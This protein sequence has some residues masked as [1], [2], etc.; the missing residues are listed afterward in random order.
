MSKDIKTKF[1]EALKLFDNKE[2]KQCKK[3]CIKG[4]EKTPNN[5]DLLSLKGITMAFL[6]EKEEGLK[7]IKDAIKIKFS[8]PIPWHFLALYYKEEKD[9]TQA[10]K[11]YT[12]ALK[13][14]SGN[15]NILRE[16]SYLQLYLRLYESFFESAKLGLEMRNSLIVNWTTYSFAGYLIG[17]YEFSEKI[18][19]STIRLLGENVKANELHELKLFKIKLLVKQSK[20]NEAIDYLKSNEKE[21]IDKTQYNQDLCKL[22][23]H[24]NDYSSAEGCVDKLIQINNEN[25]EYILIKYKILLIQNQT[26]FQVESLT[27]FNDLVNIY[28]SSSED[29]RKSLLNIYFQ[30]KTNDKLKLDKSKVGY[31]IELV[32][33]NEEEFKIHINKYLKNGIFTSN[34][35]ILIYIEW[36]YV[37]QPKKLSLIKEIIH[38]LIN[39]YSQSQTIYGSDIVPHI[40]WFHYYLSLHFKKLCDFKLALHY[41]NLSIDTTPTVVDFFVLKSK[42]L[43]KIFLFKEADKSYNKAR[44]LDVGDRYLNAKH[45]KILLRSDLLENSQKVMKEF[46]KDP[47]IDENIEHVQ[48]CWYILESSELH[49]RNGEIAQGERLLLSVINIFNS[50]FEDEFD[51]FNYCLR[52]NCVYTFSESLEYMDRLFENKNIFKSLQLINYLYDCLCIIES[53]NE[54][55]KEMKEKECLSLN[56]TVF[57]ET[58]YK[59]KSISQSKE[60]LIGYV[61]KTLLKLQAYSKNEE[62]HYILVK[63]SLIKNK[64]FHALKSLNFLYKYKPKG[65]YYT[66]S[67]NLFLNYIIN[68]QSILSN[69]QVL[70]SIIEET[71]PD[72]TCS[73]LSHSLSDT[74]ERICLYINEIINSNGKDF[75]DNL[76]EKM[77]LFVH[78]PNESKKIEGFFLEIVK[79]SRDDLKFISFRSYSRLI[80]ISRLYLNKDFSEKIKNFFYDLYKDLNHGSITTYNLDMYDVY[81]EKRKPEYREK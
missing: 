80:I 15:F 77:S 5:P 4:L 76:N 69:D 55:E 32:L 9:Y 7:D 34:P 18:L 65:I 35:T 31:K 42:I 56:E 2:Y 75:E 68:N 25:I 29:E 13:H 67:L 64:P 36:I 21:F 54:K 74:N 49:L 51:F 6:N 37:Y 43:E 78:F 46:V 70:L 38:E 20:Y 60:N 16:K 1:T 50:I 14:D 27:S 3:E 33:L 19:D 73:K 41:I 72:L 47:L 12:M 26:K 23:L 52:R 24:V 40:A 63:F 22:H 30:L 45:G 28:E 44:L 61:N 10:M 53:S 17:K 81:N 57:K 48:C 11:N 58:K 66:L 39:E 8:N 71:I 59:F 62:L 79:K